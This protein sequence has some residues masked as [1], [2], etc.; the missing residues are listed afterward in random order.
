MRNLHFRV[1]RL[2]ALFIDVVIIIGIGA[3]VG[4][5]L[6]PI[7]INV[8]QN[9]YLIGFALAV[10]YHAITNS[11]LFKGQSIGKYLFQIKVISE[12]GGKI[13]IVKSFIRSS[14]VFIGYFSTN[15]EYPN[16][17]E[18]LISVA[19]GISQILI[20]LMFYFS[21]SCSFHDYLVG[22]NVV[23]IE[24]HEYLRFNYPLKKLFLQL[25][26]LISAIISIY[27]GINL[28]VPQ[29]HINSNFANKLVTV[30][31]NILSQSNVLR[32]S[33][34]LSDEVFTILIQT[35]DDPLERHKLMVLAASNLISELNINDSTQIKVILMQGYDLGIYRS[36]KT[37][38]HKYLA[39][40]WLT[41]LARNVNHNMK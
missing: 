25:M 13:N 37:Y 29:N 32:A 21:A 19:V 14:I 16:P 41:E 34:G 5:L 27:F 36:W 12:S 35:K 22:T 20:V 33:I 7:L 6:R 31:D 17:L 15:L 38:D 40:E 23:D 9:S 1:R 24:L 3:I 8:G 39:Q 30:H 4:F 28:I 18:D 26:I 2:L 10:S 11:L